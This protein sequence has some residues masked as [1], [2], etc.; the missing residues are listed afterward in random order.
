MPTGGVKMPTSGRLSGK[1]IQAKDLRCKDR[2]PLQDMVPL[3]MPLAVYIEPTNLCNF[4]CVFCPTG[5]QDLLKRVRRPK[6]TMSIKL[7]EKVIE[8]LK[9]FG[10]PVKLINLYKDGDPLV[11][12]EFSEMVRMLKES[13]VAERVWTKTNG[14]LLTPAL[15]QRI[16]DA[17]L[18]LMGISVNGVSNEA[19]GKVTGVAIDYE[20]FRENVRD[21]FERRG[22][23]EL[24][25]K[26]A[27][28]KLTQ[29]EINKFY[30]DFEPISDYIAVEKLMGWT[31]SGLKDFTL[32]TNPDTYDGLPFTHKEVCP[33]PFYLMAVNANG[34][35]SVCAN[36]WSHQ[37]I[38]GDTRESSLKEIW[39]GE[40]LYAFRKMM[41]MLNRK[42]NA[43]CGDC[44]YL[45]IVPD[46]LD[47]YRLSILKHIENEGPRR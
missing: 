25:T 36:D 30:E 26:I 42:Q 9:E 4:R 45:K 34:T 44:Y 47:D 22:K 41:L 5:Y 2:L 24:Y 28:T 8:D 39:E 20:K 18:D 6:A 32:G 23:C 46:N 38:I 12:P 17:G 27:D 21:F 11:H 29:A 19:Y 31:N 15:N 14:A 16:V 3:A 7:L 13:N 40:R 10:K 37:T 33:Y 35:V 43:A 1:R